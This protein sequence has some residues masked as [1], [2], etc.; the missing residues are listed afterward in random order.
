MGGNNMEVTSTEVQNNF[1][2]YLKLAQIED[3][4]ITRNGKR[5]AVLQAYNSSQGKEEPPI[6]GEIPPQ[7]SLEEFMTLIAESDLR[8]EYIEGEVVLLASPT[9][10][11]QRI[12]LELANQLSR[13]AEKKPC[14]TVIAPFDITLKTANFVNIV[15][16]DVVLIC[17]LENINEKGRY[18][19]VPTLVIEVLSDSTRNYDLI[20]KLDLY[21]QSGVKEY[22]IANPK[23]EE[24]SVYQFKAG[25]ILDYYVFR[26]TERLT[27]IAIEELSIELEKIF[28]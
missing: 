15:Q 27:S 5:V 14:E 17:D 10:Q 22:W 7:L 23:N 8:Y 3:V 13:W 18:G 11:H 20:K 1:G 4:H 19:G 24:V 2:T 25:E 16:P 26:K 6:Y 12:V 21:R 9:F 28:S